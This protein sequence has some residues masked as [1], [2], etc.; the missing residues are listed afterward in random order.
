MAATLGVLVFLVPQFMLDTAY[1]G[2]WALYAWAPSS[3][4]YEYW[5]AFTWVDT[6]RKGYAWIPALMSIAVLSVYWIK[7]KHACAQARTY[8]KQPQRP[9]CEGGEHE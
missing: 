3:T 6:V 9:A 1:A 4:F 8:L 2:F 7:L 5:D